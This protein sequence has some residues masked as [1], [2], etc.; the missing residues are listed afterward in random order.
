MATGVLS[1]LCDLLEN[2]LGQA[3]KPYAGLVALSGAIVTGLVAAHVLPSRSCLRI[4][5]ADAVV[6]C[7]WGY[8]AELLAHPVTRSAS[9]IALACSDDQQ[10]RRL[11]EDFVEPLRRL[12]RS[13]RTG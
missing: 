9:F 11:R 10:S 2:P 3:D 4:G 6:A 1:D 12:V 13:G 7:V 5:R 8:S